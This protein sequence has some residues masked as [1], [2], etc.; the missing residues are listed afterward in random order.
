MH[1]AE[2]VA[3]RLYISIWH[4]HQNGKCLDKF[5]SFWMHPEIETIITMNKKKYCRNGTNDK[6]NNEKNETV[7]KNKKH[8]LWWQLGNELTAAEYGELC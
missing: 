2:P 6:Q 8:Q 3:S 5:T 1:I 7:C 4:T